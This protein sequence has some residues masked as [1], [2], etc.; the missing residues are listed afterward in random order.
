[1]CHFI[2]YLDPSTAVFIPRIPLSTN[3]YSNAGIVDKAIV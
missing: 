3:V 2:S 1:M